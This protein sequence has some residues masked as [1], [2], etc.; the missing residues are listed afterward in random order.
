MTCF[1]S[2]LI[3][4][5]RI[6]SLIYNNN[7]KLVFYIFYKSFQDSVFQLLNDSTLKLKTYIYINYL[8]LLAIKSRW[9]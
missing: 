6:Q 2:S 5:L 4:R 1:K 8:D 7:N 3:L 9:S